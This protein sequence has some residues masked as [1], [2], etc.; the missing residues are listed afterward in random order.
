MS[1]EP[2]T[3]Q[4][5]MVAQ[6]PGAVQ[7]Q[8]ERGKVRIKG[9]LLEARKLGAH[10][11][12][13][14]IFFQDI[15]LYI[16][17]G[18]LVSI[19]GPEGSGK[20]AL[21]AALAGIRPPNDG[22]VQ[23]DGVSLYDNRKTFS[24]RIGYVPHQSSA[25]LI[26]SVNEVLAGAGRLRMPRGTNARERKERIEDVAQIMDLQDERK[27]RVNALS[28]AARWRLRIAVELIAN[29]IL[30]FVDEPDE[31]HD[32][33]SELLLMERLRGL[34]HQG[35]TV[36]VI[37]RS[38]KAIQ[39][40]DKVVLLAPGG[41]LAWFGPPGN[42]I[43]YFSGFQ[44]PSAEALPEGQTA[45]AGSEIYGFEDIF[46]SLENQ[47]AAAQDWAGQYKAQPEYE[48]FLDDPLSGKIPDLLLEDRPLARFRGKDNELQPP[49]V[50][51]QTGGIQQFFFLF[52]R[53]FKLIL[54]D[55]IALILAFV[56]PL[57]LALGMFLFVPPEVYDP[58]LGD[59]TQAALVTAFLVFLTMMAA[60]FAFTRE[61]VKEADVYRRE[62]QTGLKTMPYVLAKVGVVILLAIYQG[63][64]W[65]LAFFLATVV[66]GG[67]PA[68]PGIFFTLVLAAIAG[69]IIGLLASSLASSVQTGIA[70][71]LLLILPQLFFSGGP[72]PLRN[73]NSVGQALI[74]GMPSSYAFEA[75]VAASGYGWD[76]ANDV[77]W[78]MPGDQRQALTDAQKNQSCTCM[79]ANIFSK[80][81]FP[82]VRK[83][84]T[85]IVQQPAPAQP[86]P[87]SG[88]SSIPVQPVLSPG[89]TLDQYAKAVNDYTL[90][91]ETYQ[92]SVGNY[93]S[94]LTQYM[95]VSTDWQRQNSLAIGKAEGLIASQVDAYG[96][97][98]SADLVISRWLALVG[99]SLILVVVVGVVQLG[100]GIG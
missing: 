58:V 78:A 90:Q 63:F 15:S 25:H 98:F 4:E 83:F 12:K 28:P 51:R 70:W 96:P 7:S 8:A 47:G 19:A 69:G 40:C 61:V 50:I 44:L 23:I 79:G 3:T 36:V 95:S 62:R 16:Q 66:P 59:P 42:A 14:D 52:G 85:P 57:A 75:L 73:I 71:A 26:L 1:R 9:A 46:A 97:I 35:Q 99:I 20:S 81:N 72:F 94:S 33:G 67:L 6:K 86:T 5:T 54:R 87:D 91:L 45:L 82:G 11:K 2:N 55:R 53:D 32:L 38:P 56:V 43:E 18:E 64:L 74:A 31:V 49:P 27:K 37:T 22:K 68:L 93:I 17:P 88:I 39:L 80:C 89:E 76:V 30:L 24:A 21:L 10:G 84:A 34:A 48:K 60:A 77:C 100:K 92:G 29:P 13:G 65:T 41:K